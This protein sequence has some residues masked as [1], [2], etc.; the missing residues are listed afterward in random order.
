[1]L[2]SGLPPQKA[3]Q[4]DH[5]PWGKIRE[6][7]GQGQALEL[8]R[9]LEL[10]LV[11]ESQRPEDEAAPL[12]KTPAKSHHPAVV[13]TCCCLI[14]HCLFTCCLLASPAPPWP[15]RLP[16]LPALFS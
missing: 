2:R 16:S 12:V 11:P 8:R 14:A 5:R 9:Q 15:C 1:M 13:G 3:F 4:R 7:G 6:A 10:S